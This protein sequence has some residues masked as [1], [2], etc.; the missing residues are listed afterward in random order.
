MRIRYLLPALA[1]SVSSC[2]APDDPA[3]HRVEEV[4]LAPAPTPSTPAVPA[5]AQVPTP[6]ATPELLAQTPEDTAP[7]EYEAILTTTK[8]DVRIRVHRAWSPK[9]AD[10]FFTM[11]KRGY[12]QHVAFFRVVSGFMAQFGMHGNPQVNAAWADRVISDE[13]VA[14][15][16]LRGRVT[17]ATRGPNSRSNQL[18][19]NFGNNGNLDGMGFTPFGEVVDMGPVDRLYA[20]YGEGAPQGRGPSQPVVAA[21]GNAYLAEGFPQLD[22][23]VSAR[24][25]E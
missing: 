9:G 2:A 12:F 17:F 24:I 1:L 3:N 22:Y 20:G 16:N 6:A 7:A 15:S 5:P 19:I 8:G 13:P 14:Q 25:A 11:I 4:V 18:F 10:R 21:R 23:I